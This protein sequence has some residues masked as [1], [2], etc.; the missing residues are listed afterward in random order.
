MEEIKEGD[1]KNADQAAK[2]SSYGYSSKTNDKGC[3]GKH[4]GTVADELKME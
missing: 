3:G 1:E 4:N 2:R